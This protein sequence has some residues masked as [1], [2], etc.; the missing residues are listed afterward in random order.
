MARHIGEEAEEIYKS[1]HENGE[2]L[3]KLSKQ[4]FK[5]TFGYVSFTDIPQAQVSGII[6]VL[7]D[8][9]DDLQNNISK[10]QNMRRALNEKI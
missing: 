10:L 9:E 1:L 8:I 2:I 6:A 7:Q 4:N 3:E 5:K